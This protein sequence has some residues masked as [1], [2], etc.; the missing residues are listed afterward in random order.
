MIIGEFDERGG[1][2]LLVAGQTGQ[3]PITTIVLQ[4]RCFKSNYSW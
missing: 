1:S 4:R 2:N 3:Q